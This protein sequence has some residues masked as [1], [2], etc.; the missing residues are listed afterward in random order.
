MGL[1]KAKSA[2]IGSP[3]AK[4]TGFFTGG[5]AADKETKKPS[6]AKVA[7]ASKQAARRRARAKWMRPALRLGIPVAIAAMVG[8]GGYA[9]WSAGLIGKG[10]ASAK[11]AAI[12]FTADTGLRVEHVSVAGRRETSRADLLEALG[13]KIGDPILTLD[14]NE[15]LAR[16]RALG[17]VADAAIYRQL[18]GNLHL[19]VAERQ[20]AA[21]WQNDSQFT[22]IDP[23]GE[24]IGTEG[25][26]RYRHLKVVVGKGAPEQAAN[27]LALLSQEPALESK[28]IAAVWVGERRWNIRLE[29]GIDIRLP[30]ETPGHAWKRLAQLERDHKLLSR[31]IHAI[32]LRQSDK[33]I[34]RMTEEAA[35]RQRAHEDET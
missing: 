21:I 29:N 6:R 9:V 10:V 20:A 5:G 13:V 12:A 16:V 33:L 32:D 23:A 4:L 2:G 11:E 18:P 3:F 34:V 31:D 26:D 35:E 30:E 25:L 22:L 19:H 14:L 27:L 17:W 1:S 28:V 15:M 7:K 8:G 24:I